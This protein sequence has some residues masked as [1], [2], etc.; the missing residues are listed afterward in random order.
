MHPRSGIVLLRGLP[1]CLLPVLIIGNFLFG[2]L[3]LKFV[4]WFLLEIVLVWV[5]SL[6]VRAALKAAAST[7][8]RTDSPVKR[9][10]AIDVEATV[11]GDDAPEHGG[12][13][14]VPKEGD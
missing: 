7:F 11:V 5:F 10:G 2:W 8:S 12:R 3:F 14:D 4:Y 1:G 6:Y 13:L 9:T